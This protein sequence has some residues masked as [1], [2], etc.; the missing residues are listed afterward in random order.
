MVQLFSRANHQ[1]ITALSNDFL[2]VQT[3]KLVTQALVNT[4]LNEANGHHFIARR[5]FVVAGRVDH[6]PL[7][8]GVDDDSLLLKRQITTGIGIQGQQAR[9]ELAHRLRDRHLGMKPW[10]NVLFNHLTKAQLDRALGFI[11]DVQRVAGKPCNGG[12]GTY[13]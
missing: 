2:K 12:Q 7:D 1:V 6:L 5:S 13:H 9:I 4:R 11:D 8:V 10:L 3:A